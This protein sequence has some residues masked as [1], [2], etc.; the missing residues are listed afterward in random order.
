MALRGLLLDY[1][2]TLVEEVDTDTR[3]GNE[4]LLSRASH[5]P[6]GVSLDHVLARAGRITKEVAD[7]RGHVHIETPW[8]ALTRLIHDPLGIR[9]DIPMAELEMG[10][11]KASVRTKP[12]PGAHQALEQCH[13]WGVP[14]A[15]V[16]NTCFSQSAIRYELGK[17]GLAEHLAFIVVSADYSV[18]KPHVLL[19]ETAA[20]RLGV[21]PEDIWFMGD[22]VDTDVAGAK[23]AG[24]TAVWFNPNKRP[25]SDEGADLTVAGWPELMQH[26][27]RAVLDSQQAAQQ[28][29]QPTART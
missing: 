23:A 3:A 16:S 19:F 28:R 26:V 24:M 11:W 4:W 13:R 6:A 2:G 20:A 15:V 10:F 25:G 21:L 12:M 9:F 14:V 7:R 17:H 8:P 27:S 22:R 1:G 5:R 29:I 18:R